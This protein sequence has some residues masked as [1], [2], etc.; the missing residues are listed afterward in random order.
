M[1]VTPSKSP[2]TSPVREFLAGARD[3]LPLILGAI[4]F[5]IIFGTLAQS[6]GLSAAATLAMS[7]VVFAGSSQ[8]IAIGLI[9]AG[10]ALPLILLTTFVVNLRHLLY[11]ASLVPHVR[12]L[13][14]RWKV[15]IAFWLTDETF[16]VAIR[17]YGAPQP[18]PYPHWYYLGS[19]L[20]MYSNWFLCTWLGLTVGQM[21]PNAASWGLDFAMVATFIGM[22]VPY[23]TTRPM[24]AA[25]T[26]AGS[27]ALLTHGLPHQLGLMVAALLGVAAGMLVEGFQ[28]TPK[29]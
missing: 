16:A 25:V 20:F 8:F 18:G 5:G 15:P 12:Q 7:A 29:G 4:P 24:V 19:G 21:I 11:A 13:P 6:S 27:A 23:I 26:V 1:A 9:A 2:L 22:T 10:T 28:Q 14:Q 3:I 17:H